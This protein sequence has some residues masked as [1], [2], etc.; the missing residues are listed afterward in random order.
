MNP[1]VLRTLAFLG[2]FA[3]PLAWLASL[4]GDAELLR[5][6][7]ARTLGAVIAG[8]A[9]W[10][11][12]RGRVDALPWSRFVV[13]GIIG[14]LVVSGFSLAIPA[15]GP[16]TAAGWLMS[17]VAGGGA[18]ALAAYAAGALGTSGEAA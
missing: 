9:I 15:L 4:G 5:A 3:L 18:V 8:A 14:S 6:N 17:G 1:S 16:V 11:R 13:A 10:A 2:V 12:A 7:A